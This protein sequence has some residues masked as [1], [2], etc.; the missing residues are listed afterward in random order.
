M[1]IFLK[2]LF[3]RAEPPPE[4]EPG[5]DPDVYDNFSYAQVRERL[6]A[7]RVQDARL[8]ARVRDLEDAVRNEAVVL[9]GALAESVT[10]LEQRAV[11]VAEHYAKT[12]HD[13][14]LSD[15]KNIEN[16]LKERIAEFEAII[17]SS[18]E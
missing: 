9:R 5:S 16:G 14:F 11:A 3:G 17:L 13:S 1:L 8:K 2:R 10:V 12:W 6:D 18:E 15:V 7:L 4:P